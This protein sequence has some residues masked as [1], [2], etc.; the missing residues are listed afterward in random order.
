MLSVEIHLECIKQLERVYK[1]YH[2]DLLGR[3]YIARKECIN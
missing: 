1:L 2:H 3:K